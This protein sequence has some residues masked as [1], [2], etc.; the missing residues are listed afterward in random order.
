MKPFIRTVYVLNLNT[1]RPEHVHNRI[2][3]NKFLATQ[4]QQMTL[5]ESSRLI[6]RGVSGI[7]S[8]NVS[9]ISAVGI[10]KGFA[11]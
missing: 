6:R 11:V 7:I 4:K 8:P 9:P 10:N 5:R 3:K 2:K 1:V